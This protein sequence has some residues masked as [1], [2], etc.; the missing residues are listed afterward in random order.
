MKYSRTKI[1]LIAVSLFSVYLLPAVAEATYKEGYYNAM[2]GKRK[3]ALKEAAKQCVSSHTRLNYSD[4]PNQWQYTD[5]YPELVNGNKRWWDMYSDAVYLIN[6]GQSGKTSFSANKMQ[7]EHS[8][9]KSWWKQNGDVEYTP[10]YSDLWNL[11]PSDAAANQAKLN[12]PFGIVSG[13]GTFN[14]GVSKVGPAK[15]GFGGGSGMVFEPDDRYKGD[16]ARSI[17]YMATVYD[18]LPW[19][20][21]YMFNSESWPTLRTWAY[22][23]LLQWS[24]QDPVSQKEID[25]NDRAELYQR[26]R[27]PFI[28][29]PELAEYIWGTRTTEIFYIKDQGEQVTPPIT[30]DPELTLP[31]NGEALDFG[32]VAVGSTKV[33]YLQVQG[34]NFT[35]PLSLSVSGSARSQFVLEETTI[36]PSAL[37]GGGVYNLPIAFTPAEE[38]S[39]EAKMLIYDGGLSGSVAVLLKGEGV[40]K[41][42]LSPLVATDPTDITDNS[43]R[44]NWQPAKEVVDYYIVNRVR[45]LEDGTEGEVLE[46]DTNS[47]VIEGRDPNV[48]ESYTVQSSRLDLLS[49]PS[50]TILVMPSGVSEI[51]SLTPM[52]IG[53]VEGGFSIIS[54]ESRSGLRVF[55]ISGRIFAE[56]SV[57]DEGESVLLPAGVYVLESPAISKPV[58]MIVR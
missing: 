3:E 17:F 22:D 34:K 43:Y 56:Y 33:F 25:R 58:K 47:L 15:T 2:N 23:M 8:V 11:Y 26:N 14:N 29:F 53:M 12:Y 10:A 7:R 18:D 28:D 5:V 51:N 21:N 46:S 27:N 36:I 41:P 40:A 44:A 45:Y 50:N 30:G 13:N 49:E 20:I 42:V 1:L 6:S 39:V 37:N 48:M 52:V 32:Q 31:V 57:I 38:G 9:P 55:D 24:R 4:L 16:F 35:T 19:V 54:N